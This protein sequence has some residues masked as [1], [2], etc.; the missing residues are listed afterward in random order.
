MHVTLLSQLI[1]TGHISSCSITTHGQ[2]LLYWTVSI[3]TVSHSVMALPPFMNLVC[4]PPVELWSREGVFTLP[5][6]LA[7][8]LALGRSLVMVWE[9][10]VPL[11]SY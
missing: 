8:C 4:F 11:P 2:W 5:G 10:E 1:Q 7:Q 3:C 6:S 9:Y